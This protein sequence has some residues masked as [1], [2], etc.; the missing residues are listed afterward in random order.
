[1][2]PYRQFWDESYTRLDDYLRELK[3]ERGDGREHE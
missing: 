1:M 2:E 3:G